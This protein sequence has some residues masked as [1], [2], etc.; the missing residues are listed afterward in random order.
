M[1]GNGLDMDAGKRARDRRLRRRLLSVLQAARVAPLGGLHGR[2][3]KE[4]LDGLAAPAER[5]E[6]DDHCLVLLR[7]LE[8]KGL[9]DLADVRKRRGQAFGLDYLFAKVTA[10]G[11][12]LLNE[13]APADPDVDDERNLEP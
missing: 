12:S 11:T 4:T 2:Q 9:V 7:E 8:A 6:D 1:S 5:F 3:A 13:T 10:A